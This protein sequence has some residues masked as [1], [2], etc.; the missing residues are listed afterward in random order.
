MLTVDGD[1]GV[2]AISEHHVLV[3][4]Q[5]D[6]RTKEPIREVLLDGAAAKVACATVSLVDAVADGA[7]VGLMG[8]PVKEASP[9]V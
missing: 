1:V 9:A 8:Q 4:A 5:A 3:C 7:G 2:S 6:G